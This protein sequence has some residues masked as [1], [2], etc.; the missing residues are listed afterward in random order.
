MINGN[1]PYVGGHIKVTGQMPLTA[2]INSGLGTDELLAGNYGVMV[3]IVLPKDVGA[4]QISDAI[5]WDKAYFFLQLD[6]IAAVGGSPTFP[7]QFDHHV[8]L[9]PTA[10]NAFYL[11][12][13][14]I[15]ITA[16]TGNYSLFGS[17]AVFKLARYAQDHVDYQNNITNLGKLNPSELG[18]SASGSGQTTYALSR[19]PWYF[20]PGIAG[21]G[22]TLGA[23][24]Q[25]GDIG[26]S[27]AVANYGKN[28]SWLTGGFTGK[29]LINFCVDESKYK[30]NLSDT[31]PNKQLTAGKLG[32][33]PRQDGRFDIG[34]TAYGTDQ[35]IDPFSAAASKSTPGKTP[36]EYALV[37]TS[38]VGSG[39]A[40]AV[41]S[42]ITSWNTYVSPWDAKKAFNTAT[43]AWESVGGDKTRLN[44]VSLTDT[45]ADRTI[46]LNTLTDGIMVTKGKGTDAAGTDYSGTTAPT[47]GA[48]GTKRFA[49]AVNYF[50][51]TS[52]DS[53]GE[54][55]VNTDKKVA[56]GV[57]VTAKAL[58]AATAGNAIPN[59]DSALTLPTLATST[60]NR[61]YLY[62][63]GTSAN[64]GI[65]ILAAPLFFN[66]TNTPAAPTINWNSDNVYYIQKSE[67][68]SGKTVALK[69]TWADDYAN[70]DTISASDNK[71]SNVLN[72]FTKVEATS[73]K[74][75][76]L[77]V[78]S[79]SSTSA[80]NLGADSTLLGLHT[81]TATINRPTL[82]LANGETITSNASAKAT[83]N[84]FVVDD[85]TSYNVTATK[86]ILINGNKFDQQYVHGPTAS[87]NQTGDTV[88]FETDVTNKG[89]ASIAKPVL[90]M[91]LLSQ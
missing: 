52:V 59:T 13:K 62:Y 66:Q 31:S 71:S 11:K 80:L 35:L 61:N 72:N 44:N 1:Q 23:I 64:T 89:T 17:S 39:V 85:S 15:P 86:S 49:R 81:I 73:N 36:I 4:S 41:T 50:D 83:V 22:A 91:P 38:K 24:A 75:F 77:N 5:E 32:P 78:T 28:L 6:K 68:A 9:D 48:V 54:G 53:N 69:G 34:I 3:R 10:K 2:K 84:V 51:T 18:T 42:H 8:Y 29:A 87:N 58:T 43:S 19:D 82:K 74:T 79:G 20:S 47:I 16:T 56:S 46:T 37:N 45:L 63:T 12:V 21:V 90:T 33:S 55:T 57:T 76:S 65:P 25:Q 30:G 27:F 7:M 40:G 70:A 88:T 60:A 26:W 67:L 14:G